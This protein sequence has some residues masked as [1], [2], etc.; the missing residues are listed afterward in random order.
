MPPQTPT[1]PG[2]ALL[3]VRSLAVDYHPAGRAAVHALRGVDLSIAA[4]ETVGVLGE[5]GCGKTTLA[6][7]IPRLLPPEGR[8]VGGDIRFRGR[9]LERH[10]PGELRRLRGEAIGFVFQEPGS[11]LHPL[12]RVGAQ[13]AEVLRAH[14][15]ALDA[16]AKLFDEVELEPGLM[17]SYP[18][19]LSG[20]QRQRILVAQALACDPVLIL[21]DEPTAS[22]DA[23]TA[24]AVLALLR[25]RVKARGAA[26]LHIAHDPRV[27]ARTC[28]RL[29]VMYAG[30]VVEEGS[31]GEV[32][33]RPRHP[34]TAALLACAPSLDP[35][36]PLPRP[37][38]GE[39]PNPEQRPVGCAFAPRCAHRTAECELIAPRWIHT[40]S[41]HSARCIHPLC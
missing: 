2:D 27:L 31:T 38:P 26:L 18:H 32:L 16:V 17:S 41:R 23:I 19:Q 29:L 9:D 37:I 34:Y 36:A 7:A 12:R 22:L 14:G 21:A 15:R 5:S 4:G 40:P 24:A 10:S 6:R 1:A 20:G 13:V 28:D 11:A 30:Q 35:G 25:H 39:S 8:Q 3:E 33:A